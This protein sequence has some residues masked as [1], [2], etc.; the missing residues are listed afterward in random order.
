MEQMIKS[1]EIKILDCTLRDGGYHNNWRFSRTLINSYLSCMS[2]EGIEFIELGFRFLNQNKLRGE[3]AY[4]KENFI[5][6]LKI[7]KNLSI[8]I[9]I[10]ASDFTNNSLPTTKL[11][12]DVFPELE[13][14]RIKFVRIACHYKE[15]FK[16]EP[17]IN[18][19]KRKNVVVTVNLMQ[20]SELS[21]K[22]LIKVSSYLSKK[23]VDVLYVADSLGSV[24]PNQIINIIKLI[25]KHWKNEIGIHAHDNLKYALKN[26]IK[27]KNLGT[28]WLDGTVLGMGRGPGNTK[29]EELLK[30]LKKRKNNGN[31]RC[32][33][34]LRNKFFKALKKKYKWGTNKYYKFAALNKIHPTYIQEILSDARYKKKNYQSILHNLK[35]ADSRKYNP[36]KLITSNNIYIGRPKGRWNPYKDIF[37]KNVLII[38]AGSSAVKNKSKIEK[39]IRKNDLY[40]ICLNTN[41]SVNEKLINLRTACHPFRIISDISNYNSKTNLAMPLSMLPK[42]IFEKIKNKN[43]QIRDY[44]ISTNLNNKITV[45]KNYCILPNSLAISYSLSIALAGKSKKIFLAGFDGYDVDDSKNDETDLILRIVRK[46]Y[47]KLKILS[48]TKTKYNLKN[49]IS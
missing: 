34:D 14:S 7:P 47:R 19:L 9:M 38:G 48:I 49:Y 13:K 10:N 39:F 35:Q 20:I 4:T 21:K 27:A 25:K 40:V 3:T 45:K 2:K 33:Y 44:G 41:K 26:T 16:I 46:T 6:K 11:C 30:T 31:I 22:Q 36:F 24:K 43:E 28:N 1:R 18:W 37:G 23:K 17:I 29:T 32:I 42:E 8:G 15:I 12:R 5:K